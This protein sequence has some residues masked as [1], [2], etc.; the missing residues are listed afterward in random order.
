MNTNDTAT[1]GTGLISYNWNNSKYLNHHL[2]HIIT[3][4]LRIIKHKELQKIMSKGSN[5]R[6]K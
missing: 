2:G 6:E 4:D 3:E 1:Y 5:Y